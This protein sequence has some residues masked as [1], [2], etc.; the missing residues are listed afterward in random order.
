MFVGRM[1]ILCLF[2]SVM[3]TSCA[4]FPT[5]E[6]SRIELLLV[7]VIV[8]LYFLLAVISTGSNTGDVV[9]EIKALTSEIRSSRNW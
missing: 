7:I 3:L 1:I 8:L 6:W 4:G 2:L 9:T 5:D